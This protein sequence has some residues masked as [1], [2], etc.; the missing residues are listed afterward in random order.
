VTDGIL[1]AA[2]GPRRN[3]IYDFRRYLDLFRDD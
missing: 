3:A 2:D 1:A